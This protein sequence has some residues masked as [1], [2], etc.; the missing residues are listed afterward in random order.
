MTNV[1]RVKHV[2]PDHPAGQT[3]VNGTTHFPPLIAQ[4]GLHSAANKPSSD[5]HDCTTRSTVQSLYSL[6][7]QR[8]PFHP[9]AQRHTPGLEQFPPFLHVGEH[10]ASKQKRQIFNTITGLT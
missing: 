1:L 9:V 2:G 8:D 6:S 7:L 3:Q 10:T 5:D 4:S